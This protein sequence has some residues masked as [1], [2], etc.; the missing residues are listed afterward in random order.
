[1]D[2]VREA[3]GRVKDDMNELR[4]QI[5][6]LVDRVNNLAEQVRMFKKKKK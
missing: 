5:E 6:K 2:D 4:G 1:M 3:F